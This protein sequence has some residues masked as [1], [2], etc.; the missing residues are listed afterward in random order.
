[1]RATRDDNHL[2]LG[3]LPWRVGP[4]LASAALLSSCGP[5]PIDAEAQALRSPTP[6]ATAGVV[7][8]EIVASGLERPWGFEF[9]P[10]G[11]MLVTEQAGR[12]RI[13]D[14]TGR[15][16][17][18]IAGVPEVMVTGQGGLLDVAL[19]PGFATTRDIYF[20]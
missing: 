18:P 10:D 17:D 5:R 4:T 3:R 7:R 19:D 11:R 1:M 12:L 16:G 9:L 6:E 2:L 15:L 14:S 8:V 20:S 13:V